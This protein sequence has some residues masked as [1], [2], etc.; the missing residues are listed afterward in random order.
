MDGQ[1]ALLDALGRVEEH[2]TPEWIDLATQCGAWLSENRQQWSADDLW[3]RMET[4]HPD[5]TTHEPR[6]LGAVVRRLKSAGHI[7]AEPVRYVKS[8]RAQSHLR[9]IPVH[10]SLSYRQ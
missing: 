10:R 8:K 7:D 1:G 2:A 3:E 9:P 4:R 6:A 5:V